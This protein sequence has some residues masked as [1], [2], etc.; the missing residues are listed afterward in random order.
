MAIK[1]K[2]KK[3][4]TNGKN[5]SP[6]SVVPLLSRLVLD[7]WRYYSDPCFFSLCSGKDMSEKSK[8]ANLF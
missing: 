6:G 3:I 8:S 7:E 5:R 4:G 2:G 1:K